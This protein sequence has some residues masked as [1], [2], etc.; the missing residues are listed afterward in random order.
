MDIKQSFLPW[1]LPSPVEHT[2]VVA[3][4][5]DAKT[6]VPRDRIVANWKQTRFRKD[7]VTNELLYDRVIPGL[8]LTVP[9]P[10]TS[11]PEQVDHDDDTLRLSVEDETFVPSLLTSPMPE[12]VIDELRNKYSKFRTRHSEEFVAKKLDQQRLQEERKSRVAMTPME[13][14]RAIRKAEA[15]EKAKKDIE[16]EQLKRIGEMVIAAQLGRLNMADSKR[17]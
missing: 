16:P 2:K 14:L 15:E 5:P 13:E 6:G 1:A 3:P 10:E 7:P 11:K 9:F 4:I 17:A 8:N 12:G